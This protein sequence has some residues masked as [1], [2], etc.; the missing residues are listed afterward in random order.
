M[1]YLARWVW[2]G[3][4]EAREGRAV[5]VKGG[6]VVGVGEAEE[7]R[8][9]FE[10]EVVE[11]GTT[12]V[13]PGLVNSHCHLELSAMTAPPPPLAGGAGFVGWLGE[14]M[15]RG[16]RSGAEAAE[17]AVAGLEQ[18]RRFGVTRVLD[19][20]R[21][22]REVRRALAGKDVDV[23]SFAEVTGM[24]RRRG[25]AVAMIE[26]GCDVGE[27]K[28]TGN[29]SFGLSPH[30]PYST[31]IGVYRAC[32]EVCLERGWAMMT[33]LA[34]VVEEREFVVGQTGVFRGLW[35]RLGDWSG[36]VARADSMVGWM[37][38][39]LP[40]DVRVYAA[41][42]NDL[43]EWE[44]LRLSE[45][46]TTVHCPRTHGY[47]GRERV[48]FARRLGLA[49]PFRLGT[50]SLGSCADLNLMEDMRAVAAGGPELKA[51]EIWRMAT[52]R[53]EVG[54]VALG[55]EVGEAESPLGWVLGRV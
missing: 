2:D 50:D 43:R 31:E 38:E 20:T 13:T 52:E 14:V 44:L 36:D 47:F 28:G 12:L 8:R 6:R 39:A 49:S 32:G 26:A 19:I 40:R 53:L 33:H 11:L 23:E 37:E 3:A 51:E 41:H 29:L 35:D 21:Y 34:E 16:P 15:S 42:A 17:A 48:E 22:P 55:W 18:C 10:G 9:G 4:G 46:V 27:F 30:A 7:M 24:A 45:L 5:E 25:R 54:R 1:L